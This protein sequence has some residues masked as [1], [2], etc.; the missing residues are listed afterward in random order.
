MKR[1]IE[2]LHLKALSTFKRRMKISPASA[3]LTLKVVREYKTQRCCFPSYQVHTKKQTYCPCLAS[4]SS[5][6]PT[7]FK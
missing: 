4:V 5:I 6:L 2:F 3:P 7:G 1:V